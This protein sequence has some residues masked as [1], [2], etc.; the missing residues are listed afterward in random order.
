MTWMRIIVQNGEFVREEVL[1]AEEAVR[2]AF[3][4]I[5]DHLRAHWRVWGPGGAGE[6]AWEFRCPDPGKACPGGFS[7]RVEPAEAPP[8][9]R[10]YVLAADP[11][12][13][14]DPAELWAVLTD[15]PTGIPPEEVEAQ[16]RKAAGRMEGLP[17]PEL[18]VAR[19]TPRRPLDANPDDPEVYRVSWKAVQEAARDAPA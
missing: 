5:C 11:E 14:D 4:E 2:E 3:E 7:V 17:D 15:V 12:D 10:M 13:P 6:A 1:P 16:V 8:T 9:C 19:V 18:F